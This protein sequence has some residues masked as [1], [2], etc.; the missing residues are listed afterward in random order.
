MRAV[1]PMVTVV[2]CW[3]RSLR[4]GGSRNTRGSSWR[5]RWWLILLEPTPTPG[6]V[7]AISGYPISEITLTTVFWVLPG[8]YEYRLQLS[9]QRK[10]ITKVR[11]CFQQLSVSF[12]QTFCLCVLSL[13]TFPF[14]F[15]PRNF[16]VTSCLTPT[17]FV[18]PFLHSESPDQRFLVKLRIFAKK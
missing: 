3:R 17:F 8:I 18:F 4:G 15:T 13:P 10:L 14:H 6:N 1:S 5:W 7:P 11:L 9:I 16:L 2:E 12:Y